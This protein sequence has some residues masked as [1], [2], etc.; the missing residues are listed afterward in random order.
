MKFETWTWIIEI[1]T[2]LP[3]EYLRA[4]LHGG[5]ATETTVRFVW[6]TESH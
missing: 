1:I 5:G 3:S 6:T 2:F 4:L